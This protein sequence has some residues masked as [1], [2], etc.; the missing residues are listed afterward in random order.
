MIIAV[1]LPDVVSAS[2]DVGDIGLD[3]ALLS[4]FFGGRAGTSKKIIISIR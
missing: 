1:K 4:R 2:G 3:N